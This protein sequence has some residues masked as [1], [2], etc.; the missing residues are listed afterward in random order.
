MRERRTVLAVARIDV[1]VSTREFVKAVEETVEHVS[2]RVSALLLSPP[3][4][5]LHDLIVGRKRYSSYRN[6]LNN[7]LN[8]LSAV[9]RR[10][11]LSLLLS[12]VLRRAGNKLYLTNAIIPPVGV[13]MFRGRGLIP[14]FPEVSSGPNFEVI[15]VDNVNLCFSILD[16]LEVPEVFR[17]CLFRKGDAVIAV[18]PPVLTKRDPEMT[19][20]LAM[21]RARE[22]RLPVIGVGGYA[23]AGSIQQ[24]TFIIRSDGKIAEISESPEPNIFEVEVPPVGKHYN[25]DLT[26][27]YMKMVKEHIIGKVY[28]AEHG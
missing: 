16:D 9:T 19:L 11:G 6:N 14:S 25:L 21:T 5:P 12:P 20:S 7:L 4:N 13:P 15:S 2:D 27:K 17:I 23:E 28:V 3:V 22:N 24:P 1:G 18:N 26:R 8:K 10:R